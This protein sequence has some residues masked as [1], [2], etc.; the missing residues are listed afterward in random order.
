[1]VAAILPMVCVS[2]L[3]S[4]VRPVS[5]GPEFARQAYRSGYSV[6]MP[7]PFL[8]R[9]QRIGPAFVGASGDRL[10]I[11]STAELS[12][13]DQQRLA[14]SRRK[15][16]RAFAQALDDYGITFTLAAKTLTREVGAFHS[17]P[18]I[19]RTYETEAGEQ[20]ALL[21]IFK[22]SRVYILICV[23]PAGDTDFSAAQRFFDS[24]QIERAVAADPKLAEP[25]SDPQSYPPANADTGIA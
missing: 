3:G 21:A 9:E 23:N 8:R 11:V 1:M 5:E 2:L 19:R 17:L 4:P 12:P 10:Y 14:K 13:R 24:F 22:D 7:R 6:V 15:G 16:G 20:G 18:C 25:P